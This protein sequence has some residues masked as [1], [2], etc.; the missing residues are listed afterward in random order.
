MIGILKSGK[1]AS[2]LQAEEAA[3]QV[4]SLPLPNGCLEPFRADWGLKG[5]EY[6]DHGLCF[7]EDLNVILPPTSCVTFKKLL[8]RLKPPIPFL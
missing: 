6:I 7:Q 3:L 8:I 1:G 2:V 5:H 4:R